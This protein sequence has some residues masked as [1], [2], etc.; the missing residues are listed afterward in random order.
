M[1]DPFF[2][3]TSGLGTHFGGI[4][5][6]FY[7]AEIRTPGGVRFIWK[8]LSHWGA[9]LGVHHLMSLLAWLWMDLMGTV[10]FGT[11]KTEVV[12]GLVVPT[13]V[14]GWLMRDH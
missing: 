11:V 5:L 12:R 7:Q 13:F 1:S 4:Y 8:G 6:L 9:V 2:L 3:R 14:D 10:D